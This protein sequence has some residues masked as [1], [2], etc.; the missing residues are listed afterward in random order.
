MPENKGTI[1]DKA[2]KIGMV[3][4]GCAKNQVD[5]EHMLADLK[6]A[7]CELCAEPSLCDAV[8]IN[9]CG[10]IEDAKKE[11]IENILEFA[12][13]KKEKRIKLIAVTGCLAERYQASIAEEFPE[14]DVIL[15]IGRNADL[16]GAI[17]KALEG[18]RVIRFGDKNIPLEGERILANLPFYAY[19]K[20]ADGCENCCS[21]CA[22]PLIRGA[23]RSR[24]IE[25]IVKEAESLAEKG[26]TELNVV[27]QDTTRYGEERYNKLMLPELLRRLCKIES[28][29]WV[30]VL[31]CYP[32]RVTDELLDVMAA[33]PKIVKYMDLPLQHVSGRI[34]KAMNRRGDAASLAA[35]I[36][37]IRDK[38]PGIAL[39]TTFI[40]GFPGETEEDFE[41]LV[42]FVKAQRFERLGCF[43]YSQEEDTPAALFEDQIAEETKKRRAEIVMETQMQIAAELA[44]GQ[45]G[46]ELTVLCEGYDRIAE[47]WFGRSEAD[48]PD[49]DTKVFFTTKTPVKPG[50]YLSVIIDE[51]MDYDLVGT[52]I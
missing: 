26:V 49:I 24:K 5:A 2:I 32:E 42:D 39:R 21:Y 4:L 15:G 51:A 41:A 45:L 48:A 6:S 40:A 11:S 35:L 7:G 36:A 33:E 12:A 44:E 23:F 22:I 1:K 46:K 43:A 20:V 27:A 50:D 16:A 52:R 8:I 31:Y 30:R 3:S 28:L 13:L 38:V 10:F 47:A 29:K 18:D 17:A 19:L 9:T 34:L 37:K 14:A 25:D